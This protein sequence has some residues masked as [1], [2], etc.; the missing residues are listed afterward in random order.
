MSEQPQVLSA[1]SAVAVV[2]TRSGGPV[3]A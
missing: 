1:P 3:S 2:Y